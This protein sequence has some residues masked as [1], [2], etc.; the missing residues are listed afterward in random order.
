M[1]DT[2][3]NARWI[4]PIAPEFKLLEHHT[5]A[6][7]HG[8][9][10]DML[11]TATAADKYSA[12]HIIDRSDSHVLLPGLVNAHTHIAMSLFRGLADDLP[13]L[14]WLEEHIWP[15]EVAH[16]NPDFI[17]LGTQLGIAEMLKTGTTCFND[18]YYYPDVVAHTS[19]ELG[20]RATVGMIVID[21]PSAW[22][23]D[24]N[25]YF[26]KG[27]AVADQYK[28]D[29][30]ISTVFAPH[31]PYTVNDE[32]FIRVVATANELEK[33]IHLHL[34]ETEFEVQDSFEKTGQRPLARMQ[35]LGILSPDLIAVHMTQ[36]NDEE[37]ELLGLNRVNVVHCPDSNLKLASGLCPVDKLI[38]AG[39]NVALGT[40]GAASNN[41]LDL[42]GEMRTA[43]L[44]AKVVAKDATAVDAQTALEMAT[45]NGANALGLGS[46]IGSLEVGK[47]ADLCCIDLSALNT[48]PVHNPVSQI[49]Y[50]ANA[51]QVSDVWVAGKHLL[52]QKRLTNLDENDL[53]QEVQEWHSSFKNKS[54]KS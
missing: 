34:H 20:M 32:N 9:I 11:P 1:I 36:L 10:I 18:M 3:I 33:P 53:R 47:W 30:L 23:K 19:S 35:E 25:E 49:V 48:Q 15:A 2:L 42:L 16:V 5:L 12:R 13:L 31:A 41:N 37:I 52:N 46:E 29:P 7:D 40:D 26:E 22:A 44:V 6:I 8:R 24:A 39:V 21:F 54:K 17:R 28:N 50:A 27:L 14:A 43:A 38:K 51:Q 4:L 45:I